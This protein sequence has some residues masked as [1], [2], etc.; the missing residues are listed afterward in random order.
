[1]FFVPLAA[2]AAWPGVGPQRWKCLGGDGVLELQLGPVQWLQKKLS[3]GSP[4]KCKSHD[5]LLT[6]Q[7]V[8]LWSTWFVQFSVRLMFLAHRF[9]LEV[10]PRSLTGRPFAIRVP[11]HRPLPPSN[12]RLM[13]ECRQPLGRRERQRGREGRKMEADVSP[14]GRKVSL[15]SKGLTCDICHFPIPRPQRRQ[16]GWLPGEE[17][18]HH[19]RLGRVSTLDRGSGPGRNDGSLNS[20]GHHC[21]VEEC[22]PEGSHCEERRSRRKSGTGGSC[23]RWTLRRPSYSSRRFGEAG[24]AASC[25]AALPLQPPGCSTTIQRTWQ[26][27]NAR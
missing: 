27:S 3:F 20:K 11:L 22:S 26:C 19:G 1:M 21:Q 14:H 13:D 24:S 5:H 16:L 8:R 6:E 18:V 2:P 25:G 17:L 9:K 10:C 15:G 7:S 12:V 23:S 4:L